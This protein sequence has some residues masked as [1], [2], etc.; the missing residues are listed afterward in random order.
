MLW[1][2]HVNMRLIGRFIPRH[3]IVESHE[4]YEVIEEYPEDKYLPS[5]LVY[6]QYRGDI[7]HVLFAT[8]VEG[9][10]IR[11]ITAYRPS[12]DEWQEDFKTRR[13]SS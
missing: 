12:H 2:Y 5:Y 11:I 6:S 8:D 7:F 10:N 13:H 4:E 3:S 9:D 1:T